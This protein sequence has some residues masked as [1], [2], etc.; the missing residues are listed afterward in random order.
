MTEAKPITIDEVV[1]EPGWGAVRTESGFFIGP[2]R[3]YKDDIRE[4]HIVKLEHPLP[5]IEYPAYF[6]MTEELLEEAL[7]RMGL[8]VKNY[9]SVFF[10]EDGKEK[11][12]QILYRFEEI[13]VPA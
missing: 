2:I 3:K 11:L 5:F 1:I 12:K 13:K 7:A 4:C 8:G 9:G 10:I 6:I